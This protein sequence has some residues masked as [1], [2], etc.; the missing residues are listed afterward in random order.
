MRDDETGTAFHDGLELIP[1]VDRLRVLVT[2]L[3]RAREQVRLD[4][5][6]HR[7]HPGREAVERDRGL[8][9]GIAP[10]GRIVS[11]R[12][13]VK[14]EGVSAQYAGAK[15][16]ADGTLRAIRFGLEAESLATLSAGLP[17][18]PL[19]LSGNYAGS[20]S[21]LRPC[22]PAIAAATCW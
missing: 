6:E 16:T 8:L 10:R 13:E 18:V 15:A 2:E 12:T 14:L 11:S 9:A 19:K 7:T 22:A 5:V 17:A 3:P 21:K 20:R 1:G 4:R